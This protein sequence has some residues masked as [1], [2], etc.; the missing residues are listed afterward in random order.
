MKPRR[1]SEMQI[2]DVDAHRNP[3]EQ[4]LQGRQYA[5]GSE[6]RLAESLRSSGITLATTLASGFHASCQSHGKLA[7]GY[8]CFRR[9]P[10]TSGQS[11][12]NFQYSSKNNG[13]K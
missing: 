11:A 8:E 7:T 1:E 6:S 2:G 4:K 9:M 3:I 12:D 13:T 10:L 5:R